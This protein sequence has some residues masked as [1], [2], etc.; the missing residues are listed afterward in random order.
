MLI[1]DSRYRRLLTALCC[2]L[3]LLAAACGDEDTNADNTKACEQ[4]VKQTNAL[5]CGTTQMSKY[6]V[7]INCLSYAA[8]TC[9]VSAYFQCLSSAIK[10]KDVGGTKTEDLSGWP[11]CMDKHKC[12]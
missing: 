6:T 3:L 4:W 9:D 12:N 1:S 10:C 2:A 11:S 7:G 5:T 8:L